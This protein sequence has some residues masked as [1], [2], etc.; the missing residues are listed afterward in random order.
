MLSLSRTYAGGDYALPVMSLV[1]LRVQGGCII[2]NDSIPPHREDSRVEKHSRSLRLSF[3]YVSNSSLL[4]EVAI[5]KKNIGLVCSLSGYYSLQTFCLA[6]GCVRDSLPKFPSF[7]QKFSSAESTF[8]NP[9]T[10]SLD[11][12]L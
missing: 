9:K 7:T 8:L 2:P 4:F 10:K 12:L 1:C 6:T 5:L 3:R 11:F